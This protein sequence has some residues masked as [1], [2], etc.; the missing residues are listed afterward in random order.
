MK[1][2]RHEKS[3][4]KIEFHVRNEVPK[5]RLQIKNTTLIDKSHVSHTIC[6][7]LQLINIHLLASCVTIIEIL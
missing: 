1:L 2:E 7:L 4:K 5:F 6:I 3:S